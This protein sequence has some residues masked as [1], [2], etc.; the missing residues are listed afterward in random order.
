M[1]KRITG[2][3]ILKSLGYFTWFWYFW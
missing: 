1:V 3:G 2:S